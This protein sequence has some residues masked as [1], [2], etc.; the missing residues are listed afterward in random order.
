MAAEVKTRAQKP[1]HA[2]A[3]ILFDE[4]ARECPWATFE[5]EHVGTFIPLA[6]HRGCVGGGGI[7][8]VVHVGRKG[9]PDYRVEIDGGR[10]AFVELKACGDV[11]SP[12][13]RETLDVLRARRI[14]CIVLEAD[15]A[16]DM[17]AEAVRCC[18]WL[19]MLR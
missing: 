14:P 9:R 7:A 12:A 1:E 18:D 16:D 5:R 10:L 11:L 13:Q 17:Q 8:Q 15:N 3:A 6:Q 19:R 4:A 2:F